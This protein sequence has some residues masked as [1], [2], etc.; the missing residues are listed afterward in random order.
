MFLSPNNRR[1]GVESINRRSLALA[2]GLLA[3]L[4][5]LGCYNNNTGEVKLGG[6]INFK[7]PA[8]PETGSNRVQVFTEMHYQPSFRIQ[9]VPRLLPP[10]GSVPI[11]GAEVE[12]ASMDEYKTLTRTSSD[13]MA[14]Q[15]LY[16]VNCQ[17][18]HG[19]NL[20]GNGPIVQYM[21]RGA[22]PANLRA[23]VTKNA[24][25]GELYGFISCGGRQGC[26]MV[27]ADQE[28]QSPM[29]EFSRLLSED[30][31]WALVAYL[32]GVIGSP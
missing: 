4:L 5:A 2:V 29:P 28:S 15:A 12:Y 23:D 14:G 13:V 30:E 32:R 6:A 17:V 19:Q 21:N 1:P 20:D 7:L 16:Q 9:D 11:T 25:D 3:V 31:R 10:D 26:A 24:S 18:C 8:F 22:L 27:L